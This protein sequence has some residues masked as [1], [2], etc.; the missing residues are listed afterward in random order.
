METKLLYAKD[1]SAISEINQAAEILKN[2]GLVALPTETVYGLAASAFDKDAIKNIFVAK[3]RPSDNPLIVHISNMADLSEIAKEVP[4]IAKLCME[5]FW[6]GPFTAVLKKTDKI[7]PEVSGGLDTVAVRMPKNDITAKIIETAGV[8]LAAPSA[9]RS[10]SPSPST[11]QHVIDDLT[12]RIDAIVV[13]EKCEVGLESTVVTFATNPPRLLRPG[14][15]TPEQLKEL[16]PDLVIDSA[17]VSPLEENREVASP[18]MKYKHYS[19]KADVIMVA[20]ESTAFAKYVS[21]SKNGF[22]LAL[23]FEQDIKNLSIPF[24]SLGELEDYEKQAAVLFESLR[25][26]DKK[27]YKKVAVHAP[28]QKGMGLAVY[29]RLIRAAGFK[30]IKL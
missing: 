10:G 25:Q 1:S 28:N 8:P 3:G 29:N 12:D 18:G 17:V 7:P 19:P 20:G 23:C 16:I 2:G 13:S 14:G 11:A 4:P 24:I 6:P 9:N 27:G 21:D 22:D 5:K 30:V 26:V 15:V